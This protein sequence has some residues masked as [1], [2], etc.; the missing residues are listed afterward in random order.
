MQS[1]LQS[2]SESCS[3]LFLLGRWKFVIVAAFVI[4]MIQKRRY[5]LLYSGRS[6]KRLRTHLNV[7]LSSELGPQSERSNLVAATAISEP[8]THTGWEAAQQ[9]A[10]AAPAKQACTQ[11]KKTKHIQFV[12]LWSFGP[13]VRMKE[14][15]ENFLV[16]DWQLERRSLSESSVKLFVS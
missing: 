12:N 16:G 2:S 13:I 14:A 15:M 8:L 4:E 11:T 6:L 10:G 5:Q 1:L 7:L 3:S 9:A